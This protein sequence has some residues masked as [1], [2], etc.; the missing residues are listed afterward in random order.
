MS[1]EVTHTTQHDAK[2]DNR[3]PAPSP[4]LLCAK[5][6]TLGGA[7]GCMMVIAFPN[8]T[9][10]FLPIILPRVSSSI[11]NRVSCIGF[12]SG[13]RA[14]SFPFSLLIYTVHWHHGHPCDRATGRAFCLVRLESA[15]QIPL[16]GPEIPKLEN[17]RIS[18]SVPAEELSVLFFKCRGSQ[19]FDG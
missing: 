1:R 4:L 10:P 19:S 3:H 8:S 15:F 17:D 16:K 14:I 5:Y 2:Q 18:L 12:M 11:P 13:I 6:I 7:A 9:F